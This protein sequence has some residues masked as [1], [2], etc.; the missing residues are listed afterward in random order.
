MTRRAL[1][2]RCEG[3]TLAST[4]DEGSGRAGVLIVSG[5]NEIRAGG[6]NGQALLAARLAARGIPILRFDRRGVGDSEGE[7]RGFRHSAPDIAAAL[8]AFRAA[9]PQLERV[10]AFG[11]C[12]AAAALML[13]K[14]EG[15]AGL[16]LA[17]PWTFDDSAPD[18]APAMPT[19]ALRAHYLRRLSNPA[20]LLRL[21]SGKVS[22]RGLAGSLRAMTR[23]TA[24]T[25]LGAALADGLA[26]Y[27]GSVRILLA[28]RDRTAQAFLA[29][30]DRA[31]PRLAHCPAASHSFVEPDARTW[32][33]E[34]IVAAI[35]ASQP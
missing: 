7:N 15:F 2:F 13:M 22:L 4:L 19:M 23:K 1:T 27:G 14:G 3:A 25:T 28:G 21:V 29:Q 34:Q 12:D 6:W 32:L 31:D 20:A 26:A 11:N 16:V 24:P 18:E 33:E 30:W 8:T 5:G 9:Q 35:T 17:N 10:V